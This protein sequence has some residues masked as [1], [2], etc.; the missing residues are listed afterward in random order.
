MY[1]FVLLQF[2]GRVFLDRQ[3]NQRKEGNVR[4]GQS[5]TCIFKLLFSVARFVFEAS[6][7]AASH[8]QAIKYRG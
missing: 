3:M 1:F 6:G 5:C 7:E 4:W 8:F 2:R